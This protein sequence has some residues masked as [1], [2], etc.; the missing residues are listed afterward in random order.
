MGD[1]MQK[2]KLD[3]KL[4]NF[5]LIALIFLVIYVTKDIWIY[6]LNIVIEILKPI[7]ISLIITYIFNLYL[8]KLNKYFNKYISIF[9]FL[10][11]I[12]VF[13]FTIYKLFGQIIEQIKNSS[14]IIIYFIKEVLL[15]YNIDI[16]NLYNKIDTITEYV[17]NILNNIL[18][19]ITLLIVIIS[20]SI[21][22]FIDLKKIKNYLKKIFIYNYISTINKDIESY[23]YSFMLLSIINVIEYTI[24][25]IIIGHPNYLFLGILSGILSLIP[26]FGGLITNGVAIATSFIINYRLFIRTLIGILILTI[27][28]GYVISPIIYSKSNKIHPLMVILS[29]YIGGKLFGI[30]GVI[31]ALPILVIILSSYNFFKK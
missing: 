24:I 15:K 4:V 17:P 22:I 3:Y 13:I 14:N 12:L 8:K 21:Y 16:F 31:F 30:I 11:T 23:T 18:N 10:I 5:L 25:F 2:N 6:I 19:Y 27:L 1:I 26:M 29:I 7:I 28:D 9:I 20:S